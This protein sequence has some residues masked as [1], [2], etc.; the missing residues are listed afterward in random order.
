M[1]KY[2]TVIPNVLTLA[3]IILTPI[4]IVLGIFGKLKFII[5]VAILCAITD[6][7]DGKLARKWNVVSNKGAKLDAVADKVFAIGLTL[8][9]VFKYKILIYPLILEIIISITNLYYY[10]KIKKPKSLMIGK[11]KTTLLFISIIAYMTIAFYSKIDFIANGFTYA[12]INLQVLCLIFYFLNYIDF[13]ELSVEDNIEHQKI[14]MDDEAENLEQT[15][16]ISDLIELAEKYGLY[17]KEDQ[18]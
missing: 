18:N 4:I 14:M 3:R 10:S 9:L 7:F 13:K 15:K 6:L 1:E 11:I 17:D 16:E 8:A 5:I 12:T 2:K